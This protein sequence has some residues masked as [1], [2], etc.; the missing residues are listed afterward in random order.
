MENEGNGTSLSEHQELFLGLKEVQEEIDRL[1]MQLKAKE[2]RR[3]ELEEQLVAIMDA[4]MMSRVT[5]AGTTFFRRTDTYPRVKDQDGLFQWLRDIDRSDMVKPTVNAQ[6]L[7]SLML[8]RLKEN[9]P[10]P[11]CIEVFAK[12][13]VATRTK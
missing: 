3:A 10:L 13:R 7:R 5:I 6:S 8:E 11:D 9:Q 2:Q 4:E 12:N 1:E